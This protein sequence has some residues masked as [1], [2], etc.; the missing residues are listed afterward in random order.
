MTQIF[1]CMFFFSEWHLIILSYSTWTRVKF[2][3]FVDRAISFLEGKGGGNYESNFFWRTSVYSYIPVIFH[4][5]TILL[6]FF[7]YVVNLFF[8]LQKSQVL[9]SQFFKNLNKAFLKV[10][11]WKHIKDQYIIDTVRITVIID[12]Q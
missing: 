10:V 1:F 11:Y 8:F 3:N 4:F 12:K 9:S 6:F 5:Y 7:H 2:F